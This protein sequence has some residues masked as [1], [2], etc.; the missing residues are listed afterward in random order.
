MYKKFGVD[1]SS[2]NGN[3]DFKKLK[4][5]GVDFVI[6]RCAW[7]T[8]KDTN[9]ESNYKKAK[10][11]GLGVGAYIYTY[12]LNLKDAEEESKYVH[13]IL[14]NKKFDY[15]VYIDQEDVGNYKRKNKVTDNTLVQITKLLCDNLEKLGYYVG[16]YASESW[17]NN[18][19]KSLNNDRYDRWVANWGKNTGSITVDKSKTH[20]LHQF[21]DRL[22]IGGKKFDGDVCYYDYPKVIKKKKKNGYK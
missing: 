3:V 1:I 8:N 17:F 12:A 13:N 20:R 14:K 10:E 16:V 18:E 19:L 9:F 21:T 15:P 4:D 2:H 22:N 7:G 6:L 5:N 11:N